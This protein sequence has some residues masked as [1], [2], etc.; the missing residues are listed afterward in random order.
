MYKFDPHGEPLDSAF[1]AIA[2]DQLDEALSDLAQPDTSGRSI[3]HEA[4]R[5][6][7]KL[8]GLLRLVRLGFPGFDRENDALR[9]AAASLSHLRDREV[10]RETLRALAK[11]RPVSLLERL[12]AGSTE[13][14]AHDDA[15]PLAAFRERMVE[16]RARAG[17]WAL[18]RPGLETL[19]AGVRRTYRTARRRMRKARD[20]HEPTR[21]HDWRKSNKNYGFTIDLLRKA[22]PDLLGD[23]V[24]VIDK[25]S[26]ALGQHHDLVVLRIT[27]AQGHLPLSGP[28]QLMEL[29][30]LI[31]ERLGELEAESFELGRQVYAERPAALTRRIMS[32]WKSA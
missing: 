2:I 26:N 7:K 17:Q 4:R 14:A 1:R 29:D 21:F 6:T 28:E 16:V 9:D 20:L 24:E 30:A 27:A 18:S 22:A 32:Y 3:V 12:L 11:W 5:R 25:L 8:R 15:A 23:D 19:A 13:P 31:G 10:R